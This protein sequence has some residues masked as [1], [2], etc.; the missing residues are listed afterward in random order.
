MTTVYEGHVHFSATVD[1]ELVH[2]SFYTRW[3][4]EKDLDESINRGIL[5]W[6]AERK[7]SEVE[8]DDNSIDIEGGEV[9]YNE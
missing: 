8:I 1:G 7:G 6:M 4:S 2:D 3:I 5:D 9:F